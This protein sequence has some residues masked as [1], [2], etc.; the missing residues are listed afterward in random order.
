MFSLVTV[1]TLSLWFASAWSVDAAT[2]NV[3][4]GFSGLHFS[5]T[6]VLINAGDTVIWT[7]VG[8]SHSTTSGT[9][10]VSGDDN[11]VPSGL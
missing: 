11:G 1:A 3:N 10:G 4:V 6:N 9:N 5:P 2:T 8:T 7:W